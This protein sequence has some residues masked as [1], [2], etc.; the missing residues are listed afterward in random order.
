MNNESLGPILKSQ[1]HASLAMLRDAIE[2]CPDDLWLSKEHA[3]AYWQV[4]YHAIFF[5]HLYLFPN[6]A[7]FQ[8]WAGHQKDVQNEDGLPGPPEEGNSLPLLPEPY[9][10]AQALRYWQICDDMVDSALDAM[11]LDDPECGFFW[12][13]ISKFEHQLV[14]LRH[15]QHHTAQL[16]DRLRAARNVGVRWVGA[17]PSK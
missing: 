17:R 1:Y 5:A 3:N 16:A 7:A 9:T 8:P 13:K 12:Y 10:K 2:Q 6:H 15:I 11:N 4:A 14:N